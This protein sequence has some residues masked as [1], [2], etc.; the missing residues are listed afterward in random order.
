MRSADSAPPLNDKDSLDP[1]VSCASNV[2]SIC[3][4]NTPVLSVEERRLT[5]E[6]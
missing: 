6:K 2:P 4:G 1:P 3:V 5:L